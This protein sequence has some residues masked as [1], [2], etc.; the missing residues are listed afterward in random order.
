MEQI[1]DNIYDKINLGYSNKQIK[2]LYGLANTEIFH[3]DAL[4]KVIYINETLNLKLKTTIFTNEYNTIAKYYRKKYNKFNLRIHCDNS[5]RDLTLKL[6]DFKF[7]QFNDDSKLYSENPD[8]NYNQIE[9]NN[10]ELSSALRQ[11]MK[12]II[13]S[14]G[15]C[16][17]VTR[18]VF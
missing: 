12:N 4:V 3:K 18:G 8:F 1:I 16:K 5:T 13:L 10:F 14:V 9:K 17:M 15:A 6:S 2:A 7:E 11:G